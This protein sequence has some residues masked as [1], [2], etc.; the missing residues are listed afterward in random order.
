M[1][2]KVLEALANPG[3]GLIFQVGIERLHVELSAAMIL[4]SEYS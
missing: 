3:K 2:E 4:E 1:W